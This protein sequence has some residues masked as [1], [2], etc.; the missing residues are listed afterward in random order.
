M[1]LD[2]NYLI[3]KKKLRKTTGMMCAQ[4]RGRVTSSNLAGTVTLILTVRTTTFS[5]TSSVS[6]WQGGRDCQQGRRRGTCGEIKA[7]VPATNIGLRASNAVK[8]STETKSRG[9]DSIH[10]A[11]IQTKVATPY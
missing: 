1:L 5:A 11:Y 7:A 8:L 9:V 4:I 6:R 3:T 2:Y 10:D